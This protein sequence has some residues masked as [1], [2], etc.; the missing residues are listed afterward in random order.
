METIYRVLLDRAER[1]MADL[2]LTIADHFYCLGAEIPSETTDAGMRDLLRTLEARHRDEVLALR[3]WA[4]PVIPRDAL[5]SW[6]LSL[7]SQADNP[8]LR[9]AAEK[10]LAL[11]TER[12]ADWI[13]EL[14]EEGRP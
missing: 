5:P 2:L 14:G 9:A 3:R 6:L 8:R 4:D 1:G 10:A 7:P 11:E 12:P 13:R